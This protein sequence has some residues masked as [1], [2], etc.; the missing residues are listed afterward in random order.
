MS[1]HWKEIYLVGLGAIGFVYAA[2]LQSACPEEFKVLVDPDHRSRIEDAPLRINGRIH[3][4]RLFDTHNS[5]PPASL[6]LVAVKT[7]ELEAAIANIWSF[8][9]ENTIIL[10]L[11]NGIAPREI[12]RRNFEHQKV[13]YAAVY[14]NATRIGRDVHCRDL[15]KLVFGEA[16]NTPVSQ[17]VRDLQTL[18]H[19]A[20][21]P[22]E[23]PRD[24]VQAIWVKFMF[25][26]AL[27]QVSAVLRANYGRLCKSSHAQSLL[28]GRPHSR[29]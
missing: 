19:K 16:V 10:P 11:M 20:G 14:T 8:V 22:A 26:V 24:M 9:D 6:L 23:T 15:G 7:G 2:H 1:R 3:S 18:F 4:F 28:L 27:N 5:G 25:N 13:L 29:C 12:L 17:D 21:I